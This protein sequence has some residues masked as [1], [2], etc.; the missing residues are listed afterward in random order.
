LGRAFA[1][2]KTL[3]EEKREQL[4]AN[5]EEDALVGFAIES[6]S[7]AEISAQMLQPYGPYSSLQF[8]S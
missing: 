4:F 2:S 3:K 1:D 6:I 5:I 7:A 8:S